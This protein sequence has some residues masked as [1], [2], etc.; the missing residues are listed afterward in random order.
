MVCAM[1]V[2][3]WTMGSK[4][5]AGTFRVGNGMSVTSRQSS[6]NDGINRINWSLSNCSTVCSSL[7]L[8][9]GLKRD[10]GATLA[11]SGG[12]GFLIAGC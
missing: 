3:A 9:G 1:F 7:C 8:S 10:S 12:G 2:G 6:R 5:M 4:E 11:D